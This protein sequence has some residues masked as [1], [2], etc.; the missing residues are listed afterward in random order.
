MNITKIGAHCT[1]G[2]A[3]SKLSDVLHELTEMRVD[4]ELISEGLMK[5]HVKQLQKIFI[6]LK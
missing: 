3:R 2:F 1:G 5:K 4:C 6:P